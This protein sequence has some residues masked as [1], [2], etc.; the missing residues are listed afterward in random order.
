[1]S[2]LTKKTKG[3]LSENQHKTLQRCKEIILEVVPNAQL[4]L[5]GSRARGEAM[6]DSNYD[7]LVI[8]DGPI[9]WQ[10]ER[11]IGDRIYELE[12]ETDNVLSIQV[13]S[14]EAW[15]SHSYQSLPFHQNVIR[16][17]ITI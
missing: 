11:L 10:L 6:E 15:N 8:I 14:S 12:L 5:Y 3:S 13:I 7:L 1:M 4:I 17:G 16:N 2:E 9:N